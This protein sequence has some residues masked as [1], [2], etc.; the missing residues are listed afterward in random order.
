LQKSMT[1][2]KD[3]RYKQYSDFAIAVKNNAEGAV[4]LND[5]LDVLHKFY[6][7]Q[8][9]HSQMAFADTNEVDGEQ[10]QGLAL[11]TVSE[12]DVDDLK[13]AC[14]NNPKCAGFSKFEGRGG[15]LQ[16]YPKDDL[17][18]HTDKDNKLYELTKDSPLVTWASFKGKTYYK[19][20]S[21]DGRKDTVDKGHEGTAGI[22]GKES[23][24]YKG[25]GEAGQAV[26]GLLDTL[27]EDMNKEM[28]E[29][30][31]ANE[32][33]EQDYNNL[34]SSLT[35][36]IRGANVQ[37][38]DL[39]VLLGKEKSHLEHA[40]QLKENHEERRENLIKG[41]AAIQPRCDFIAANWEEREK[42]RNAEIKGI[43]ET[44]KILKATPI[45]QAHKKN[46][47][48]GDFIKEHPKC[49]EQCFDKVKITMAKKSDKADQYEPKMPNAECEACKRGVK[50]GAYCAGEG[51]KES[52][53]KDS[54]P[55]A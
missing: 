50:V 9:A 7:M 23:D 2:S 25:Q 48:Y 17:G 21:E 36:N 19:T 46:E 22:G 20:F 29:E 24:N 13:V 38:R 32:I 26:L 33:N 14:G 40:E 55:K 28:G 27:L 11:K 45:H 54:G 16:G 52:F 53:C 15:I 30:M 4:L 41:K 6:D 51:K 31:R 47:K 10:P 42:R 5:A 1:E 44:I 43:K 49:G 12:G 37:V 3:E 34:I 39:S 35:A 8:L 18:S